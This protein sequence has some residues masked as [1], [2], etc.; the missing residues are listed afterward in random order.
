MSW[1]DFKIGE[2]DTGCSA[3]LARNI[4]K[5]SISHNRVS[6]WISS[7]FLDTSFRIMKDTREG[8]HLQ[9]MLA[10]KRDDADISEWIDNLVIKTL[11]PAQL[12]LKLE[13]AVEQAFDRGREFQAI[14][15]CEALNYRSRVL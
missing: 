1:D 6:F 3:V 14:M 11:E 12:R 15:I 4:E 13:H 5:L 7:A 9:S 2:G 8:Q 10:E